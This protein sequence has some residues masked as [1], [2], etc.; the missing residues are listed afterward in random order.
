M[1]T[2][3]LQWFS[4]TLSW[5]SVREL[6]LESKLIG[7]VIGKIGN[8]SPK[9]GVQLHFL[10]FLILFCFIKRILQVSCPAF[11][12]TR[13]ALLGCVVQPRYSEMNS[14]FTIHK[15]ENRSGAFVWAFHFGR[16]LRS[17]GQPIRNRQKEEWGINSK[18]VQ[19]WPRGKVS[20]LRVRIP[21]SIP[22]QG[23]RQMQPQEGAQLSVSLCWSPIM[24]KGKGCVSEGWRYPCRQPIPN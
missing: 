20:T 10:I 16:P 21:C 3:F 6:L 18:W 24:D 23:A 13:R 9:S 2:Q 4:T 15:S 7:H 1:W 11:T 14:Q 8:I 12:K 19:Q 17:T 22:I 5:L